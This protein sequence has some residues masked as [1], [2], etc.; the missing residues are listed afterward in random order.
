MVA[1][2][3]VEDNPSN[4]KLVRLIL[5]K[6]GHQIR[7]ASDAESA[8]ELVLQHLTPLVLM[9]VQLP[10]MD[11]LAAARLLKADPKTAHI[12]IVAFTANA[13]RSEQQKILDAGC[14]GFLLKPFRQQELLDVVNRFL[15]ATPV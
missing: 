6:A 3:V 7:E 11:G 13:M 12:K 5:N 15:P 14:D 2:T 9:D 1:I 10:G 4:M 8:I